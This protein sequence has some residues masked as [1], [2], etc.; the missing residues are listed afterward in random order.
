MSKVSQEFFHLMKGWTSLLA[1]LVE[2][3]SFYY[4]RCSVRVLKLSSLQWEGRISNKNCKFYLHFFFF[5]FRTW[6]WVAILQNGEFGVDLNWPYFCFFCSTQCFCHW[7]S[8]V[9]STNKCPFGESHGHKTKFL[10]CGRKPS[11]NFFP[12]LKCLLWV[13]V[14]F[15]PNSW[16]AEAGGSLF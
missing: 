15:N 16:K 9:C 2:V 4:F 7:I 13:V 14:A 10:Y 6:L 8:M 1:V 12:A 11:L 3:G 5:Y